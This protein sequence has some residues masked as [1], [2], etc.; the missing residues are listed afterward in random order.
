MSNKML[1]WLILAAVSVGIISDAAFVVDE[2][3]SAIVFQ[4]GQ[5]RD[6]TNE[7]GLHWKIP[8]IQSVRYFDRRVLPLDKAPERFLTSEK[9][10]VQVDFFVKWKIKDVVY[11]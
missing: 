11:N 5:M 9:K 3:E 7:P 4:L 10:N 6:T 1:M 2:R 8:L